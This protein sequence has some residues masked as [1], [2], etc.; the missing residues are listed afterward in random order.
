M[1]GNLNPYEGSEGPMIF[2]T[3]GRLFSELLVD[4]KTI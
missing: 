1:N 3:F 4:S 2:W